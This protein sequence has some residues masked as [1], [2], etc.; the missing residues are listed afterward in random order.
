MIEMSKIMV[1]DDDVGVLKTVSMMLEKEG[2]EVMVSDSGEMCLDVLKDE[3]P[4]M[5]LMD[6]MMP[7]MDGW[8]VVKEIK[9]DEANRDIIIAI[10]TIRSEPGDKLKS[11]EVNADWHITK[12]ATRNK[13]VQTVEWLFK[14]R[15]IKESL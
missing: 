10:M 4:D 8:E 11:L 2:H 1:V 5:I 3:K 6:I 7:E 9:K 12:P 15:D 14:K 13:V